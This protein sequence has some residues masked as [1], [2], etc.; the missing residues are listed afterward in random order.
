MGAWRMRSEKIEV[1]KEERVEERNAVSV[2][3]E[4]DMWP[5]CIRLW[6]RKFN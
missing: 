1:E 4:V 5:M 3:V 6:Y 2:Q